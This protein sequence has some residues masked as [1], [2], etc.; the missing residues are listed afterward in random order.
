[1]FFQITRLN[2]YDNFLTGICELEQ[3]MDYVF[4]CGAR[5]LNVFWPIA[6]NVGEYLRLPVTGVHL[7]FVL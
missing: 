2:E 1:M 5:G 3:N 6:F 7:F 4:N